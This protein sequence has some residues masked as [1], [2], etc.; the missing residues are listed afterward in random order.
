ML[1][2]IM[3]TTP[4]EELQK[5][6]PTLRTAEPA[7][8]DVAEMALGGTFSGKTGIYTWLQKEQDPV[9]AMDEVK[10]EELWVKTMEWAGVHV[11]W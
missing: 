2:S 4:L 9:A 10:Q 11:P 3:T 6:D 8:R 5:R 1:A 7:G